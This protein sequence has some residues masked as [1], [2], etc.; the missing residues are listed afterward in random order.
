M[1]PI[2]DRMSALLRLEKMAEWLAGNGRWDSSHS[3]GHWW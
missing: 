3:P 2:H 1:S